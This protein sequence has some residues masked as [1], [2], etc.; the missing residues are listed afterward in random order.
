M[1]QDLSHMDRI[2]QLQD[3]IQRVSNSERVRLESDGM[4]DCPFF[5]ICFSLPLSGAKTM[6]FTFE[7]LSFA[8][9]HRTT[10]GTYTH[11][12]MLG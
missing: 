4:T 10:A 1:L 5:N 11:V 3:E 9:R 8:G 7:L 2:T 12:H 6:G